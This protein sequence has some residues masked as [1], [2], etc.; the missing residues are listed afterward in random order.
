MRYPVF[1]KIVL[2]SLLTISFSEYCMFHMA[3]QSPI[4]RTP[5]TTKLIEN[6]RGGLYTISGPMACGKSDELMRIISVLRIAQC[7]VLACKHS[8]DTRS[9]QFLIS[10][11]KTENLIEAH[12]ISEPQEILT[13]IEHHPVDYV[14]IDE[15]Q[16]F[17]D[18]PM[19]DIIQTLIQ[20]GIYV[21]VSGLDKDFKGDPFGKYAPEPLCMPSLL[22]IADE[23]IKL[24]A[25]CEVCKQWN[26]TMTQRLV[27]G[28]PA[29]KND[30]LVMVDDG[31]KKEIT[32]E[33]RCRECHQLPE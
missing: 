31:T 21:I 22:A 4:M 2:L 1:K 17:K 13:E 32:Y 24:K 28:K 5:S 29:S 12:L 20:H 14:A 15:V 9:S 6:K 18:K 23:G 26:A 27:N 19:T 8:I 30:P 25:V 11:R 33:P 16:F 7:R 3:S 10:R